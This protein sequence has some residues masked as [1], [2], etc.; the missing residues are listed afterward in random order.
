MRKALIAFCLLFAF[1][2]GGVAAVF[3]SVNAVRDQVVITEEVLFGDKADVE[4][5]TIRADAA[6]DNGHLN[7]NTTHTIG[8]HSSTVTEYFFSPEAPERSAD[9]APQGVRLN[10]HSEY[11]VDDWQDAE[12]AGEL[13]GL[14]LAYWELMQVAPDGEE[15]SRTIRLGDYCDYYSLGITV[16][17]PNYYLDDSWGRYQSGVT[18]GQVE[19]MKR[20]YAA[21]E[22]C[23]KIPVLP[24]ETLEIHLTRSGDHVYSWGSGSGAGERYN[25]WCLSAVTEDACYF[26]IYNYSTENNLMDMSQLAGGFGIY[27][28]P[29]RYSGE[30]TVT[31][32]EPDKLEMVYPLDE[33]SALS[34]IDTTTDGSR[35]IL[36]TREKNG[37]FLLRIIDCSSMETLQEEVLYNEAECAPYTH[38]CRD[39]YIIIRTTEGG[40]I[41]LEEVGDGTF[42][43]KLDLDLKEEEM[44][45]YGFHTTHWD[46]ERLVMVYP[47]SYLDNQDNDNCGFGAA[48]YDESGVLFIGKYRSSLDTKTYAWYHG[49]NC[50]LWS[51]DCLHVSWK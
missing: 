34:W 25:P 37:D 26:A 4:G 20:L 31:M 10:N 23:L 32:T 33:E 2:M 45:S 7:W 5:L 43:R 13:S 48:V 9:Y 51:N 29:Y 44:L 38:D 12:S 1:S 50:F 21:L 30:N 6:L 28:F 35:L 42:E 11:M 46:G 27:R 14:A 17:L 15:I 22:E 3:Q 18:E 47:L 41:L 16:E 49:E 36:V 39:D 19:N 24:D 40:L 8:T